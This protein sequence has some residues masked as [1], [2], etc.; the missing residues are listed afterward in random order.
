MPPPAPGE[1][2]PCLYPAKLISEQRGQRTIQ[3]SRALAWRW[4]AN[5][6]SCPLR[7]QPGLPV[8]T[9]QQGGGTVPSGET[10]AQTPGP[11]AQAPGPGLSWPPLD[12]NRCTMKKYQN[13]QPLL[14]APC[15]T[16]LHGL[17]LRGPSLFTRPCREVPSCSLETSMCPSELPWRQS[18]NACPLPGPARG[19]GTTCPGK[20]CLLMAHRPS[21]ERLGRLRSPGRTDAQESA[22]DSSAP[23]PYE[24]EE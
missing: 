8:P 9:P 1:R 7:A 20:G 17:L 16:L 21:D 13:S 15:V 12:A 22:Y 23:Y 4:G 18:A 14:S 19:P 6:D 2:P 3:Q 5:R 10:W 24:G 11:G